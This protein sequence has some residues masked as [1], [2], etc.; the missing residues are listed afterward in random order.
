MTDVKEFV[1]MFLNWR[2]ILEHHIIY[3]NNSKNSEI[4]ASK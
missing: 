4:V 3:N 1:V 2:Q